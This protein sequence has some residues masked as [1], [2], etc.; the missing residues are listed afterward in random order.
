MAVSAFLYN[1]EGHDQDVDLTAEQI[2]SIRENQLLWID[3][4]QPDQRDLRALK[5]LL[6]LDP[7][8]IDRISKTSSP[9]V[10]KYPDYL[11]FSVVTSPTSHIEDGRLTHRRNLTPETEDFLHFLVAD[12]WIVT[13]HCGELQFFEE[14]RDKDRAETAIGDLSTADFAASL[15]DLHLEAF[16][17]EIAR[18]EELVDGLDEQALVNPSGRTLLAR[19]VA[20]R[21]RVAKLRASLAAQRT[22]FYSLSRPDLQIASEAGGS[23][24]LQVLISRYERA[25]DEAEHARDLVVGSFELFASRT[26]QKT[27]EL[28]QI[29]TYLTA[30]I[31][32]CA[33]VAGLF[34]MNFETRFFSSGD[35]GFYS[36]I[37]GLLIL[38]AVATIV[39]RSRDWI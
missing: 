27:N 16:F 2:R 4:D 34:G 23:P 30:V 13:V 26:A 5:E 21:R 9:R 12:R 36:T 37:I 15:L 17:D 25:L 8:T 22:V 11:Q 39:A 18:I 19:M 10:D 35:L 29:L 1:A 7:A 24:H 33:A 14:F 31:G 3:V 6:S 38:A 20:V 32:I 28:V